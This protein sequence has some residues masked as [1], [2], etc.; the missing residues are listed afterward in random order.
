[1][2]PTGSPGSSSS[3]YR[4]FIPTSKTRFPPSG[5][6]VWEIL[7]LF[8]RLK[9]WKIQENVWQESCMNPRASLLLCIPSLSPFSVLYSL[10]ASPVICFQQESPQEALYFHWQLC[11]DGC[12]SRRSEGPGWHVS[13]V[14]DGVCAGSSPQLPS[15]PLKCCLFCPHTQTCAKSQSSWED[16]TWGCSVLTNEPCRDSRG[17]PAA[18]LCPLPLCAWHLSTL[19]DTMTLLSIPPPGSCPMPT[20]GSRSHSPSHT[21]WTCLCG[22]TDHC[23]VSFASSTRLSTPGAEDC[24][25]LYS[26]SSRCS[27]NGELVIVQNPGKLCTVAWLGGELGSQLGEESS[28][29]GVYTLNLRCPE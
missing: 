14:T 8:M 27:I 5:E 19:G 25:T 16:V 15:A 13:M 29:V 1:M 2:A 28:S 22:S 12:Q 23:T 3:H 26:E 17:A 7:L 6:S 18:A 21:L 24:V 9:K 20:T 4:P 10:A 11:T